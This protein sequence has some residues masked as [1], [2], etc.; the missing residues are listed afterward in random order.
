MDHDC[1]RAKTLADDTWASAEYDHQ[2]P[3]NRQ[4]KK[5]TDAIGGRREQIS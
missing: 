2:L 4:K 5:E 3:K 1:S